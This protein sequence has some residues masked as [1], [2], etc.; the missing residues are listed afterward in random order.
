MAKIMKVINAP[1]KTF[2]NSKLMEKVCKNYRDNNS[3]FITALSVGALVSKDAYGCYIY[4][5]QNENNKAI[6][7]NK[8][9]FI[10]ALDL[11]NGSLMILAQLL[12]YA[13]IAKKTTQAKIFDKALGKFFTPQR[14]EKLE[15]KILKTNPE[16]T[17]DEF[18]RAF[19]KY[20]ENTALAFTHLFTLATTTIFAKRIL[21]PFIATPMADKMKQWFIKE[22]SGKTVNSH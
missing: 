5:K 8:R 15:Q 11:A 17:K 9:K 22:D 12:A 7:E 10:S 21:V 20:K 4:V 2:A 1:I 13:T 3:K 16:I 18:Q 19:T 6:P 14:T